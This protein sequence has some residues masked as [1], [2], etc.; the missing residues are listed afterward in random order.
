MLPPEFDSIAASLTARYRSFLV[1]DSEG[2][3]VPELLTAEERVLDFVRE[4]GRDLIQTFVDV[5]SVQARA[6]RR[7]CSC[8]LPP[9]IHRTTTWPRK[10]LLGVVFVK[11]PYVYCRICHGAERPLHS[12]LGTDRETWSLDVQEAAV[13]LASDESCGKAVAKLQRHH[14]GVEMD[15][16][17]ALRMLHEHGAHAREFIDDKLVAARELAALPWGLRGEGATELEVEWD[18]GMIP[19]ATLEPIEPPDGEEPKLTPVRGLPK[20]R[21]MCRWEEAKVGLAQ[22]PG[23]V[24]RLYTVRPTGDLAASFDDLLGLA[25]LKGW[26]EQTQVRG[27]AD[28]AKHIRPRMEEVFDI[29]DFRFILDRPHCKEHLTAAGEALETEGALADGVTVQPWAEDALQKMEV[30]NVAEVVQELTRAWEAS[31]PDPESRNERLR[32]EAGYFERNSDAVAYAEYRAQGWSTASSEVESAQ[33]HVVQARLKISGAWWH[34]ARVDD[35]LALRVLKANGWWHEYW[36]DRRRAW[37][38]RAATFGEAR[39]GEAA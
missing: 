36:D 27:L 3:A 26:T 10:T 28:G 34:P 29:G 25:C 18:A 39:G 19:V 37:R 7:P 2:L 1:E 21:K 16:T 15:R 22:K 6:A 32:L 9:S 31:D 33:G 20:R 13:D 17:A 30:G 24:D 38:R 8:D 23:E 4:L 14:P 12:M 5:R 35:I 11:D